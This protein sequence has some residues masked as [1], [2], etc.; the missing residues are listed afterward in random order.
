MRTPRL[1]RLTLAAATAVA[2]PAVLLGTHPASAA[3]EDLETLPIDQVQLQLAHLGARID[4]TGAWDEKTKDAWRWFNR[5][6]RP[7]A[8]SPQVSPLAL[9]KLDDLA[10]SVRIPSSCR[11]PGRV[12]LCA[13]ADL[14]TVRLFRNGEQLRIADAV[15]G[16]GE[17]PTRRGVHRIHSKTRFLISDL[18]GVAMPYSLFFSGGQ[19]LHFSK[20]FKNRGYAVGTLGCIAVGDKSFAVQA[21]R[22]MGTGDSVVV[23]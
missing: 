23:Y 14:R 6:Y 12:V 7:M 3:A 16:I 22:M 18:S 15:F 11:K 9:D 10:A 13:D 17:T 1:S 8:T 19:A 21:Y 20:P 4:I 5:K 2:L